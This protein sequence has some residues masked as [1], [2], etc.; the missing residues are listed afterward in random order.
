MYVPIKMIR[1]QYNSPRDQVIVEL[2]AKSIPLCEILRDPDLDIP[3]YNYDGVADVVMSKSLRVSVYY[4]V[5][6]QCEGIDFVSTKLDGCKI[7]YPICP[8]SHY[9]W[10]HNLY[11]ACINSIL[12]YLLEKLKTRGVKINSINRTRQENS[13]INIH[14]DYKLECVEI[15]YHR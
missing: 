3:I 7:K 9:I 13:G 1:I 5:G 12:N 11:E 14:R 15:P 10:K 8:V 4:D 2:G 6:M